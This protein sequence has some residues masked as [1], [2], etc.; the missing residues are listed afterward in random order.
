[1]SDIA[2]GP[3][4]DFA[5]TPLRTCPRAV[6]QNNRSPLSQQKTITTGEGNRLRNPFHTQPAI[7]A[8]K[9]GEVRQICGLHFFVGRRDFFFGLLL[10]CYAPRGCGFEPVQTESGY[11]HRSEDV[12]YRVQLILLVW[13]NRQNIRTPE[14]F[15]S[16]ARDIYYLYAMLTHLPKGVIMGKLEGK[17]AVVTGGSSG[18]ALASAKRFVE[19]GAYVFITGRRQEALDEAVKLIGRNVTGV[20]G[21]AANLDDLDRLFDTVKREKGRS[22]SCSQALA[23]ARPYHW[24]KLP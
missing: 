16:T 2:V 10:L 23:R 17:V 1:M 24:A 19:E 4:P 18:M 21:D 7:N 3:G 5:E 14:Q 13:T 9:H 11:V 12:C 15:S 8:R 6:A 20:R 22:T